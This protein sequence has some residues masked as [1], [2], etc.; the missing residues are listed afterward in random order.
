[1]ELVADKASIWSCAVWVIGGSVCSACAAIRLQNAA[2][3][4]LKAALNLVS[5]V[6][7]VCSPTPSAMLVTAHEWEAAACVD[8]MLSAVF[9]PAGTGPEGGNRLLAFARWSQVG[10]S[11]L[12]SPHGSLDVSR[13]QM[14]RLASERRASVRSRLIVLPSG[15]L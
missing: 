1:M 9:S 13:P 5:H 4:P 2:H 11:A 6:G 7:S 8:V 12:S 14:Q 15:Y 3:I 10:G